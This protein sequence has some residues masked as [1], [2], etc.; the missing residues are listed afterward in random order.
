MAIVRVEIIVSSIFVM[1]S[2][3]TAIFSLVA[4]IRSSANVMV[5]VQCVKLRFKREL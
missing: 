1:F 4:T 3:S 5:L 2:A